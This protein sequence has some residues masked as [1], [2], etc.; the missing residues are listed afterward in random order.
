MAHFYTVIV[1]QHTHTHV[2]AISQGLWW[3]HL[4][5]QEHPLA[6]THKQ[7]HRH[8][9]RHMHSSLPTSWI[10][11]IINNECSV[12][13][14]CSYQSTTMLE[15]RGQSSS[16]FC[17]RFTEEKQQATANNY[18]TNNPLYYCTCTVGVQSVEVGRGQCAGLALILSE[19]SLVVESG[20]SEYI[21]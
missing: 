3:S 10:F 12:L 20:H 17:R 2:C 7:T 19:I 6:H 9:Q 4:T 21:F 14:L 11:I 15:M 1:P 18:S 13:G 5:S 8:T 16:M